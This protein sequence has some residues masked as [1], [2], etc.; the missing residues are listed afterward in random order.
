MT[1]KQQYIPFYEGVFNREDLTMNEAVAYSCILDRWD[2]SKKRSMFFDEK[3]LAYYVIYT[4]EQ[5]AKRIHTGL[6]TAGNVLKKIEAKGLIQRKK[7]FNKADKIFIK[8]D[9]R[10]AFEYN[11][12]SK[13]EC[14]YVQKLK[15][16][17]LTLITKS[18]SST[19]DTSNTA[20]AEI[21]IQKNVVQE[22]VDQKSKEQGTQAVHVESNTERNSRIKTRVLATLATTLV[23]FNGIPEDA[24]EAMKDFSYGEPGKLHHIDSLINKAKSNVRK[25][26]K[27]Q[28]VSGAHA[29]TT[30]ENN[31]VIRDTFA[32]AITRILSRATLNKVDNFDRFVMRSL[33]TYFE[34]SAAEYL[35][36]SSKRKTVSYSH[37]NEVEFTY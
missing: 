33:I 5:I 3:E 27:R 19:S 20:T 8:T 22:T 13:I 17:H 36:E 31:T 25:Q 16:N 15:P 7:Q 18:F 2:S 4:L 23:K 26:I 29:A 37:L 6:H 9:L 28:G 11:V 34:G 30:F 32:T 12:C 14:P 1:F 21:N 24:V 10:K 35:L